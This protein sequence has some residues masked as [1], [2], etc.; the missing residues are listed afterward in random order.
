MGRLELVQEQ[1]PVEAREHAHGQEEARPAGDPCLAVRR[2]ATAG[3]D[4][5]DVRMVRQ[6]LPP[7][8]QRHR[9]A[10]LGAEA[11]RIGGDRLQRL[12]CRLE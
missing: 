1:A 2:E 5:V 10:D 8:V 6:R 9:G 7:A 3:H 4:T 11:P 12:P